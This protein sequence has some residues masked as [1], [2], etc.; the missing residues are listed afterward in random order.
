M[1][2]K[3]LL[4]FGADVNPINIAGNTPLDIAVENK[5]CNIVAFL[6]SVDG[7][8][9]ENIMSKEPVIFHPLPAFERV[10][11]EGEKR[12]G[13]GGRERGRKRGREGG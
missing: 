6:V 8:T 9:A 13:E 2:V 10:R 4:A 12:E 7:N 11:G 3:M 5:V 1:L